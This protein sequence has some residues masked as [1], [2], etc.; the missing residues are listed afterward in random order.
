MVE[1]IASNDARMTKQNAEYLIESA[2]RWAKK[3]DQSFE[4][5]QRGGLVIKSL[6]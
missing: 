5:P 3:Q 4:N 2:S 1:A 6:H